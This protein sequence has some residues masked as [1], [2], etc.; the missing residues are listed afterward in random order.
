MPTAPDN[1]PGG[2]ASANVDVKNAHEEI[3]FP[4]NFP[5]TPCV[6]AVTGRT[7][8]GNAGGGQGAGTE[9]PQAQSHSSCKLKHHLCFVQIC[10]KQVFAG[11]L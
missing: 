10:E 5:C 2:T 11:L 4:G 6:A 8:W 1:L 7:T 9:K 3:L